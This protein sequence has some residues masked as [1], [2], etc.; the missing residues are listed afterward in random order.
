M[1]QTAIIP[2]IVLRFK[3]YIK[4]KRYFLTSLLIGSLLPDLDLF[5]YLIFGEFFHNCI[6]HNL[7]FLVFS[8][9]IIMIYGEYKKDIKYKNIAFGF[10][11][12]IA[13]HLLLNVLTFQ[14]VGLFYPLFSASE[15][16]NLNNIFKIS[17]INNLNEILKAS[18]FIF[19]RFYGWFLI[20]EIIK[21][22]NYNSSQIS[23][24]KLWM[25]IELSIFL[26]FLLLIYFGMNGTQIINIHG[27]L[28]LPSLMAALY[29]TF[30]LR[31]N[32][33]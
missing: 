31:K 3:N 12:G 10:I 32:I 6:F 29:F 7:F 1:T 18:D 5:F 19:F 15:N 16:F 24:I 8:F 23:K 28:L 14:P 33:Q 4:F 22:P 26:L 21:T 27:F 20:E 11:S 2:I 9:L 17:K 25:K 30:K 13:I